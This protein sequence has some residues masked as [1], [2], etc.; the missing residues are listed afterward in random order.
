MGSLG[1]VAGGMNPA[2]VETVRIFNVNI[3]DWSV[4]CISEH[5]NKRYFDA[6]VMSPYFHY[7]N[8]EGMYA[9]PEVGALAW[10]CTPSQGRMA[11][12]FIMG[13]QAPFDDDDVSY[14]SNRLE[15]N[16]GDMMMRTRDE[17]FIIL[18]R[19]GVVQIGST[20]IAQRLYVPLRNFIQDFCENYQLSTFGGELLWETQRTD[21]TTTGDAPTKFSLRAKQKANDEEYIA[22]M[23]I[24]SH[25]DDDHLTM[26][27]AV[28]TDGSKDREAVFSL[29]ITNEGNVTWDIEKD[30]TQ[31]ITG[32]YALTVEGDISVESKKSVSV[33][34]ANAATMESTTGNAKVSGKIGAELKG[35][36]TATI[37]AP[38]IKHG[39]GASVATPAVMGTELFNILT[40][41]A[42]GID[43]VAI[44]PLVPLKAIPPMIL[45]PLVSILSTKNFIE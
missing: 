24:G 36:A 34:A 30:W 35:G 11:Q 18:R 9:M 44:G 21:Q 15:L 25:K 40:A 38:M 41:V 6:Q 3:S 13:Y 42:N 1:N 29:Q 28:W 39:A 45:T 10:Y 17:S 37:E 26:K 20:P 33:K 22:E 5:G 4:D 19:G 32:D 2:Y 14:R 23:T 8:G 43:Q 31:N 27:L 7:A 16:P 12:G